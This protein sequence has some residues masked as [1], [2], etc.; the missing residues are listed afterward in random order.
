MSGSLPLLPYYYDLRHLPELLLQASQR[1]LYD[2]SCFLLPGCLFRVLPILR[3]FLQR[4]F[5]TVFGPVF[6]L[7][8]GGAGPVDLLR[9]LSGGQ[10]LF[11]VPALRCTVPELF[12]S[13][14]KLVPI[15]RCSCFLPHKPDDLSVGVP[16]RRPVVQHQHVLP[17]LS[18]GFCCLLRP[19]HW[20]RLILSDLQVS[21]LPI[22]RELSWR[23]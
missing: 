14:F 22:L 1:L 20:L 3:S 17:E 10:L 6:E 18:D 19:V 13:F 9:D 16:P 8:C 2:L 12:W 23:Q 4:L 7:Q 5:R 15:L 21:F 11:P